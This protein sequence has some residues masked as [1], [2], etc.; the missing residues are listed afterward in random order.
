MQL[1]FNQHNNHLTNKLKP[2]I[3]IGGFYICQFSLHLF[4]IH[5]GK[6]IKYPNFKSLITTLKKTPATF[7]SLQ[8]INQY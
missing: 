6:S 4:R 3:N 8:L 5:P 1:C 2:L 7:N